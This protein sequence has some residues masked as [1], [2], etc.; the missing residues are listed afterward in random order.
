MKHTSNCTTP[1]NTVL[2]IKKSHMPDEPTDTTEL[3]LEELE[4]VVG[5]QTFETYER[6][7]CDVINM[8]NYE[9]LKENERRNTD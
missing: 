6:F 9:V 2:S 5:G 3:T 4:L 8:L 1:N 7:R